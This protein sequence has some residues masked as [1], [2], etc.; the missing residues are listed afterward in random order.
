MPQ[1]T[2]DPPRKFSVLNGMETVAVHPS[3]VILAAEIHSPSQLNPQSSQSRRRLLFDDFAIPLRAQRIHFENVTIPVAERGIDQD[4]EIV[5]QVH[6]Q[7]PA[8]LRGHDLLRIAIVAVDAEVNVVG[9]VKDANFRFLRRGGSLQR[10][11]LAEVTMGRSSLPDRIVESSINTRRVLG[12]GCG[13]NS[14]LGLGASTCANRQ[15][16]GGNDEQE[17]R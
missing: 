16:S 12:A 14:S 17:C 6:R 2:S 13:G 3:L 10:L 8:Q 9:I 1:L 4:G 15:T 11:A 7:V 5:V